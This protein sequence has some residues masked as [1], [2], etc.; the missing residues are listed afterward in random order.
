MLETAKPDLVA[1]ATPVFSHFELGS[2]AIDA[3]CN[4]LMEKPLA[5]SVT[6]AE[7]LCALAARAGV[8]LFVDHTFTATP[9]VRCMA[10]QY[11]SGA[12]GDVHYIDSV[13]INFGLFQPDIDVVWD[14]AVHDISI[15]NFILREPIR[16][17]QA[18]GASHNPQ[19]TTDVA[20][21]TIMFESGTFAHIHVS[22][23]SPVKVR[24]MLL[25]GSQSSVLYD[26]VEMAEKVKIYDAKV[27]FDLS[28]PA[29]RR[30]LLVNY[31]RGDMMAPAIPN[32]EALSL[33]VDEIAAAIRGEATQAQT[34]E[35]G[36]EVVRVLHAIGQSMAKEGI[37]VEFD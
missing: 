23:L 36:L 1:V 7:A 22:W 8:R 5:A 27:S 6:E 33:V 9:A 34:G 11:E 12:L 18:I 19:G 26:D 13:R 2:L 31:R 3:G 29:N 25:S 17:V 4:V 37:P 14:L 30:H 16:T 24:R 35:D 32:R 21:I 28:S 10:D 20:Y 15:I